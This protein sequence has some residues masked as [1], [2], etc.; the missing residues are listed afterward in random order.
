MGGIDVKSK[1][2]VLSRP[3]VLLI[4]RLIIIHDDK[5]LLIQR[6]REDSNN[7]L[8]WEIPGGKL[9]KGQDL[10]QSATREMIEE[11]GLFATP[12]KQLV[13]FDSDIGGSKKYKGIPYIQLAGLYSC[14]GKK[15]R[16]SKEHESYKWVKLNNALKLDLT[17]FTR[18]ALLAWEADIDRFL[19]K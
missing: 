11:V 8:K 4:F 14:E 3:R 6:S 16:L 18:K 10:L 9:D 13:F 7:P 2:P 17:E 1:N 5:I 15:V 19:S 12:V